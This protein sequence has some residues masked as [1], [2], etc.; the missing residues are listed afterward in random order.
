M[1]CNGILPSVVLTNSRLPSPWVTKAALIHPRGT[2]TRRIFS[3]QIACHGDGDIEGSYTNDGMCSNKWQY[4]LHMCRSYEVFFVVFLEMP[5]QFASN[6]CLGWACCRH[7]FIQ[8][9]YI[10][11]PSPLSSHFS[12]SPLHGSALLTEGSIIFTVAIYIWTPLKKGD[13]QLGIFGCDGVNN[14][15]FPDGS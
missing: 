13:K 9:H 15:P 10:V 8:K 2:Y 6:H 12:G 5:K 11:V 1:P 3:R 7:I 14:P 4:C